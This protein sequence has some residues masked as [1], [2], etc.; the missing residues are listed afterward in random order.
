MSFPASPQPLPDVHRVLAVFA[1]PD[2]IDFGAAGTIAGWVDAGIEVTYLL[3]TRGEAG[4]FDDTPREQIPRIREAE[5][6]AAA[7]AVGVTAVEFLDGYADGAVYP[8][9]GLRRDIAAAIR[10]HRPQRVLTNSP[11]PRWDFLGGPNHPDHTAVGQAAS[12]AVYPDAR[13]PYAH[14]ELSGL[15]PWS[16]GEV[17][18]SGGP[19]PDHFVDVTDAADRKFAALR[20]HPSQ[21]PDPEATEQL[22]RQYLAHNAKAAGL[23]DGRLAESFTIVRCL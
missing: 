18:Y 2:D 22:L 8:T 5:Q 17:W 4:G 13:N 10:R 16:V 3:V 12:A 1:H 6:R 15:E 23:P 7:A 19:D 9:H 14:P 21:L 20:A 11:L